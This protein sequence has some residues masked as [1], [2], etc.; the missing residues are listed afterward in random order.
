MNRRILNY[1]ILIFALFSFVA[2][3]DN[4]M[5]YSKCQKS[6]CILLDNKEATYTKKQWKVNSTKDTL[7]GSGKL[8]FYE[9]LTAADNFPLLTKTRENPYRG[10][11]EISDL[12][13]ANHQIRFVIKTVEIPEFIVDGNKRKNNIQTDE[14]DQPSQNKKNFN[15]KI[16]DIFD[17]KEFTL[18]SDFLL[19][20]A[21]GS[22]ISP[23]LNESLLPE[24][25]FH[26]RCTE[27][28]SS[29]NVKLC[30]DEIALTQVMTITPQPEYKNGSQHPYRISETIRF[31]YPYQFIKKREELQKNMTLRQENTASEFKAKITLPNGYQ[32]SSVKQAAGANV[33]KSFVIDKF[34]FTC[35]SR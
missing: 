32:I 5:D 7:V 13:F 21:P 22:V 14:A 15:L 9:A 19:S 11:I 8:H 25:A 1:I 2:W 3:S 16:I 23:K 26:P 18:A 20:R 30:I 17:V 34:K 31:V 27:T 10:N 12:R 24:F 29:D 35:F 28:M 33:V 4:V 6:V